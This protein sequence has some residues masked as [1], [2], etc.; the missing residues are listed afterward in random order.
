ML[1]NDDYFTENERFAL[2]RLAIGILV[3]EDI[4]GHCPFCDNYIDET[5][6]IFGR[7]RCSVCGQILCADDF[8]DYDYEIDDRDTYYCFN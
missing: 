7:V 4:H 6:D 8:F 5:T 3:D 2:Q 1:Y